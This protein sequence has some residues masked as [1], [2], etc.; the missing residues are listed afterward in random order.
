[1][2]WRNL[3]MQNQISR[4]DTLRMGLTATSV[5]A[6]LRIWRYPPLGKAR[7][8]S[9]YRYSQELQPSPN[10][11]AATRSSTSARSTADH[12]EG[13]VLRHPALHRPEIDPATY[14]LK[15]TGMVNKPTELTLADLRAMRSTELAAGYECSGNSA[16]SIQGCLPA[17][18]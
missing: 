12:A 14:R 15:L 2:D 13:S 11:N 4:R 8:S 7:R 18:A 16:R 9:L 17:E 10:P 3:T 6:L 1:M 5:L